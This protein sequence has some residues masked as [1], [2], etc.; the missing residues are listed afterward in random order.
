[1][2][3][4]NNNN[5]TF[6]RTTTTSSSNETQIRVQELN[7]LLNKINEIFQHTK[8]MTDKSE[9]QFDKQTFTNQIDTKRLLDAMNN[10]I[11]LK[12]PDTS[13]SPITINEQTNLNQQISTQPQ[14]VS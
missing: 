11:G 7:S 13:S 8:D 1:N 14:R 9:K 3:N 6:G 4:N 2:N 10:G 12:Q 5:T